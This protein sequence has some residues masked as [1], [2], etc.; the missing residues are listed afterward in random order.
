MQHNN[1]IIT[2]LLNRLNAYII[3]FEQGKYDEKEFHSILESIIP[4]ITELEFYDL[5]D[6][7]SQREGD[8]ELIDFMVNKEDRRDEY[9]V[10]L[11]K[12]KAYLVND[13]EKK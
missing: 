13:N 4:T 10:V 3:K 9:M 6:F 7:L 12:I 2:D 11:L 5:R 1:T 8:L